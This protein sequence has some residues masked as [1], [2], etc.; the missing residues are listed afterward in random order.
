MVQ[1]MNPFLTLGGLEYFEVIYFPG[2]ELFWKKIFFWAG[3][4]LGEA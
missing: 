2:A 4:F 3:Y 1:G